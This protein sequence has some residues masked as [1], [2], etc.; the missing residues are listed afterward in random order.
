[1]QLGIINQVAPVGQCI[2]QA[3]VIATKLAA[4]PPL[5]LQAA[6][7][8]MKAPLTEQVAATIIAEGKVF[9]E[10]LKSDEAQEAINAFLEKRL[11]R[12]N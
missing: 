2:E 6:K 1:M 3:I 5:A 12:F 8:I 10:R 9:A 7:A 11:P 4:Q